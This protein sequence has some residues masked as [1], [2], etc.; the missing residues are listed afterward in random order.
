MPPPVNWGS[1]EAVQL[2]CQ[3]C[4]EWLK[5]VVQSGETDTHAG[6]RTRRDH[7]CYGPL[8]VA[9][10]GIVAAEQWPVGWHKG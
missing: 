8:L 2:F 10:E 5:V 3:E 7:R 9:F 6:A 1:T 4:R